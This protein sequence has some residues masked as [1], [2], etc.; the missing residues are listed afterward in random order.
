MAG[1]APEALRS[2]AVV[3][4]SL[5]P[6]IAPGSRCLF[7]PAERLPGRTF[8]GDGFYV[9]AVDGA[10]LV[11]RV[12][13]LPGGALLLKAVN[14]AYDDVALRPLPEADT[15]DAYRVEHAGAATGEVAHVRLV[16]KVVGHVRPL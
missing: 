11:K 15:P 8:A 1:A 6:E 10:A 16:G 4:D 13:R 9:L 12:Q 14:P 7:L 2:I 3:G 5:L